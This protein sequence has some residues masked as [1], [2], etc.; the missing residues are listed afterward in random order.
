M[1][2]ERLPPRT[3][4]GQLCVLTPEEQQAYDIHC[5]IIHEA[6]A[7][8][9]DYEPREVARSHRRAPDQR[10]PSAP[11]PSRTATPSPSEMQHGAGDTDS[12]QV[13][14]GFSPK[15]RTWYDQAHSLQLLT[16]YA[17]R[18]QRACAKNIA[19]LD[20]LQ[21]KRKEIAKEAMREAKLLYQLAQAEGKPYRPEAYF[22]TAPQ[23]RESVFSTPE[24]AHEISRDKLFED[25]ENYHYRGSLP[26]KV[27]PKHPAD[28]A[29]S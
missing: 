23:T 16:I 18:I 29:A 9:G 4:T 3:L 25:A 24:V 7:P 10:L 14:D 6:L 26:K 8:V 11:A 2:P 17:Q 19:Y 15:A 12:S 28:A 21:A 1:P 13:D 20:A 27:E 5:K 22:I